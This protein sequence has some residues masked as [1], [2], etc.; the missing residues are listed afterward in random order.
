MKRKLCENVG[1]LI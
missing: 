1:A